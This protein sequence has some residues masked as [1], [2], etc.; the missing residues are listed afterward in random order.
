MQKNDEKHTKKRFWKILPVT[1]CFCALLSLS[2]CN[3]EL[4]YFE[5][6]SE[7]RS[8]LLLAQTDEF[9]LRVF[10]VEKE[11][12]YLADGIKRETS[13]RTEIR[14]NTP[15][16][17]KECS[18]SFSVDGN[19]YGGDM[20]FDIVKAEYY[21]SCTLDTASLSTL[22]CTVTYWEKTVVLEA[23]SVLTEHTLSPREALQKLY[24]SQ[25]GVFTALT[26]EYGFAG[27]IQLR[28]I[29]EAQAYYYIG[30]I[31]R[32]GRTTA[33]LMNGE[34]GKILAKRES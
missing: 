14:L 26:D 9:Y 17:D 1:L 24:D 15:T 20:S 27:E 28:L 30:V 12:P 13:S 7:V 25:T 32:N 8:N 22:A 2:A 29:Y 6:A 19:G 4:D 10:S 34:T 16:G 5:Y 33:Y 21:Y 23:Q 3:E 18:V 31:D 11:Q